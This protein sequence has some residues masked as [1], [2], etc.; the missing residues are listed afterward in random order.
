[1]ALAPYWLIPRLCPLPLP[2]MVNVPLV[3]DA[4]CPLPIVDVPEADSTDALPL[5]STAVFPLPLITLTP[6]RE[7]S[8]VSSSLT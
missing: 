1:M 8:R 3:E 5:L 4:V 6:L 2:V 7:L